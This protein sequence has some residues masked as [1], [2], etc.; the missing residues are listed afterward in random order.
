MKIA[1]R[2]DD[3]DDIRSFRQGDKVRKYDNGDYCVVVGIWRD[4]LWLD[5]IDYSDA[6]PFTDH[7]RDYA[8]SPSSTC[9][10]PSRQYT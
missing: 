3:S 1:T 6:A 4:W 2:R 10:L 7:A 5:P 8:L 9:Q